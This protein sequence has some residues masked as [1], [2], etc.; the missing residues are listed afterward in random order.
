MSLFGG[1]DGGRVARQ[2]MLAVLGGH[3]RHRQPVLPLSIVGKISVS[4]LN[5]NSLEPSLARSV[6]FG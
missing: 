6:T 5:Y 4:S 2:A 3:P 1:V